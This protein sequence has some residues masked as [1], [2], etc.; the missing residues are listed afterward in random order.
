VKGFIDRMRD[1]VKD[2]SPNQRRWMKWGFILASVPV[3]L[4]MLWATIKTT[5]FAVSEPHMV[6]IGMAL[7]IG[8]S[9]IAVIIMFA[10]LLRTFP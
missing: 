6:V 1:E 5:L 3:L 10:I 2:A 4:I 9:M 8:V 7:A